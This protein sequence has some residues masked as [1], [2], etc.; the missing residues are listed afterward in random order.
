MACPG[1]FVP[2]AAVF[3]LMLPLAALAASLIQPGS[4]MLR[5][6]VELLADAGYVH[7]PVT[8]WPLPWAA[9]AADLERADLE[10][11]S[12]AERAAW[13]RLAAMLHLESPDQTP[14]FEVGASLRA[15]EARALRWYA[16][17]PRADQSLRLGLASGPRGILTYNLKLTLVHHADDG[18]ET[19]R[20]DGSYISFHA[21][22][23]LVNAGWIN[24]WWGPGWSGSMILGTNARPAPG[25]ALSRASA[26]PFDV[27]VLAWLGPWRFTLF[28]NR[29]N[30]DR[31]IAHPWF[32][33]ARF[34]VRPLPGLTIG[35]S[36][37]D[38]WGGAGRPEDW[39]HFR[40]MVLGESYHAHGAYNGAGVPGNSVAGFDIRW[41]FALANQPF[42]VYLQE[43]GADAS[44][45]TRFPRKF[46]GLFG[47]ETHGTLGAAGSWR[48]FA[49]Y[50]DTTVGFLGLND[51]DDIY[52]VAYE[53]HQYRS[54]YRYRGRPIAYSTDN[55]SH[56][57]SLGA[58]FND[59]AGNTFTLR[60]RAGVI[61]NDNRNRPPPGGNTVSRRR[62]D[63]MDVAASWAFPLPSKTCRLKLAG[64][65]TRLSPTGAGSYYRK[66]I[67]LRWGYGF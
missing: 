36:R 67:S 66:R 53:N 43:G 1:A 5:S 38:Q 23:W 47:V 55:D 18:R 22:H 63:I 31:Y 19:F 6:D 25:I 62:A 41:H 8:A 3:L 61:N 33:G 45:D 65:V 28:V 27:P 32:F 16:A 35:L 7:A 10:T 2:V 39:V 17:A 56:L 64:G 12:P 42:A 50:T 37:T 52:N 46:T 9:I 13:R 60:A 24:R 4:V 57:V 34:T 59:S 21:G 15:G 49:E 40:D 20:P 58:I 44:E 14:R 26:E 11:M 30:S 51:D 29:L 54:G 48:L